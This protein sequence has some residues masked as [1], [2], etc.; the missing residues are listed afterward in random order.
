MTSVVTVVVGYLLPWID[1]SLLFIQVQKSGFDLIGG[2][3]RAVRAID[4]PGEAI[5]EARLRLMLAAAAV[6]LPLAVAVPCLPSSVFGVRAGSVAGLAFAV[7]AMIWLYVAGEVD[8][9]LG[10]MT[11]PLSALAGD[12]AA[13]IGTGV[14]AVAAGMAGGVVGGLLGLVALAWTRDRPLPVRARP[15]PDTPSPSAAPARRSP[16]GP[17]AEPPAQ[18]P[19]DTDP[20]AGVSP[21]TAAELPRRE[22]TET[23]RA[24]PARTVLLAAVIVL[25][26]SLAG[27]AGLGY[28]SGRTPDRGSEPTRATVERR[29]SKTAAPAEISEAEL[30]RYYDDHPSEFHKPLQRRAAQILFAPEDRAAAERVLAELQRDLPNQALFRDRAARLSVDRDTSVRGGD[31][32]FVSRPHERQDGE[33]E[34][35]AVVMDA[36]W[37]IERVGDY[38][39][40]VRSSRGWHV[41][42]LTGKR[43]ALHLSFE[44][45]RGR[46]RSLLQQQSTGSQR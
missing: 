10:R 46:I 21:E 29:A 41:V 5:E 45:A 25:P 44:E 20:A 42:R 14:Y 16:Q 19:P 12:P 32:G 33:R 34:V 17:S 43:A 13:A 23:E 39:P 38:A 7:P 31:L 1:Q 30:R 18:P 2:I 3:L 35:P 8:E 4:G 11:G 36:I 9:A 40:L 26:L 22:P 24:F 6:S 15:V 28:W 27:A 37:R